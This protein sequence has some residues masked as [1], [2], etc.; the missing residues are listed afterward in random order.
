MASEIDDWEF[1]RWVAGCRAYKNVRGDFIR[2]VRKVLKDGQDPNLLTKDIQE[3][4]D[5]R[6]YDVR[7]GYKILQEE[8]IKQLDKDW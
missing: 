8:W 4:Q 2:R 5:I 6:D 1:W 3:I 7:D